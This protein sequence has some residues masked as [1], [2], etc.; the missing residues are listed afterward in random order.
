LGLL[1]AFLGAQS[2]GANAEPNSA[3]INPTTSPLIDEAS[4]MLGT[5]PA[6]GNNSVNPAPAAIGVWDFFQMLLVLALVLAAIY[7]VFFFVKNRKQPGNPENQ[8]INVLASQAL[9]TNRQV[10][11]VE[12]AQRV[13][14]LGSA[15]GSIN[16]LTEISDGEQ[17]EEI[18]LQAAA[19][20]NRGPKS[21]NDLFASVFG[22]T[23]GNE[24][25]SEGGLAGLR[26]KQTRL[27]QLR[28]K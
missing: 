22:T 13:L 2:Q 9:A 20:I 12:I 17:I 23:K 14:V 10:Y 11:V 18:R 1:L 3:V 7:G 8:I 4:I 16:I 19:S 21:F 6:V 26:A 28:R 15:E 27:E 25:A 24:G 5:V